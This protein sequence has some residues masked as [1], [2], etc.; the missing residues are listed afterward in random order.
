M[1]C[2]ISY[3]DL[4][5]TYSENSLEYYNDSQVLRNSK[6]LFYAILDSIDDSIETVTTRL[7]EFAGQDKAAN[8]TG[9]GNPLGLVFVQGWTCL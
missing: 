6:E 1:N 7:R 3:A 5:A 4:D 9:S 8:K 2:F